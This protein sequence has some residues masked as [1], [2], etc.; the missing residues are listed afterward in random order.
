MKNTKVKIK[1]YTP[2]FKIGDIVKIGKAPNDLLRDRIK[3]INQFGIE[4]E[5]YDLTTAYLSKVVNIIP[6][7]SVGCYIDTITLLTAPD[8]HFHIDEVVHLDDCT[9]E[10]FE[11]LS[12]EDYGTIKNLIDNR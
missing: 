4:G 6:L 2:E 9:N 3:D 12:I 1:D 10:W 7:D 11:A 8:Y 5:T